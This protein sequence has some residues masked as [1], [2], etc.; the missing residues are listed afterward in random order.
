MVNHYE[1]DVA[2]KA[3]LAEKIILFPTDTVWSIG[4]LPFASETLPQLVQLKRS[5][6]PENFEVLFD[7]I[8][9][10]KIYVPML[11][12][13]IETL[14]AY[15]RRPLT[16]AIR[17]VEGLPPMVYNKERR[18]AIRIVQ[19]PACRHIIKEVDMPIISASACS[20]D[21]AY[22]INFGSIRSDIIQGVDYMMKI[23]QRD[24]NAQA[25]LSVKMQLDEQDEFVFLRE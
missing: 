21:E 3:L 10:L 2:I 4:C 16:I 25:Q 5:G 7:S 8:D 20:V 14:F 1:C 23:R 9:R 22:P 17:N 24:L 18:V 15:H 13:K 6:D 12:P 19:D 11:H